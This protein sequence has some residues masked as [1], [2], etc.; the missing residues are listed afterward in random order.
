MTTPTGNQS[1]KLHQAMRELVAAFLSGEGFDAVAS[2][3]HTKIST[4]IDAGLQPDVVG[5]EGIW[6]DVSARGAHRLSVDL[7]SA[8]ATASMAGYG[9]TALIQHRSARGVDEAFAVLT[10]GDLAKLAR[11]AA[12]AP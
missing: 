1:R 8:R 4:A 7:D 11:A 5:L 6:L 10:L 9:V 12:P 2:P 3:V